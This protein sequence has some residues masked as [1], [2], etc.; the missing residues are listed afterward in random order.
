MIKE[1]ESYMICPKCGYGFTYTT[2]HLHEKLETV[3]KNLFKIHVDK[4]THCKEGV[5]TI[6][7]AKFKI[8]KI[9][10]RGYTLRWQCSK[11]K[12]EWTQLNNYAVGKGVSISQS[13]EKI[14]SETICPMCFVKGS[15]RILGVHKA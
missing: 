13:L 15:S 2:L 12:A 14:K 5:L 3:Y 1:M 7:E 11:C 4:C 8:D 6:R 10:D 9:K